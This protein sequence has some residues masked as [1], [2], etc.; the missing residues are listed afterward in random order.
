MGGGEWE[1][2][3]RRGGGGGG[4]VRGD[5][6]YLLSV[7]LARYRIILHKFRIIPYGMLLTVGDVMQYLTD[8]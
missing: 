4:R 6:I 7:H 8:M 3:R 5:S 2:V 1:E